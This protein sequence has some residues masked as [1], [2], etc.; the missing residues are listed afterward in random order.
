MRVL[1]HQIVFFYKSYSKKVVV[2]VIKECSSCSLTHPWVC[3]PRWTWSFPQLGRVVQLNHK[4]L[5]QQSYQT[6]PF[7]VPQIL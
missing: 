6:V 5:N 2:V 1:T 3:N 7:V 4:E